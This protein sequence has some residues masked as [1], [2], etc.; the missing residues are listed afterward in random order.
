VYLV[1]DPR[2][3]AKLY[4]SAQQMSLFLNL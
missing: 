2:A 4:H 1:W 3:H